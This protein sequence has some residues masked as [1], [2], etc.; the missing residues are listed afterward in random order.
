MS[1]AFKLRPTGLLALA[2]T[3]AAMV[4][5]MIVV[6]P[7]GAAAP[8]KEFT[9]TFEMPCSIAGGLVHATLKVETKAK[10]PEFV[11]EGETFEFTEASSTVTAPA[12]LSTELVNGFGATRAKG[13]VK[14]TMVKAINSTPASENIAVTKLFPEGLPYEAPVEKEKPQVFTAPHLTTYNFPEPVSGAAGYTVTGTAGQNVELKLEHVNGGIESTLE[15]FNASGARVVSTT[16][17]CEP[18]EVT[19]GQPI[20]IRPAVTETTEYKNIVVSGSLTVKRL[21]EAITLPE[22]STFNGQGEVNTGTGAG[23]V[24]GSLEI[25][26]FDA[27]LRVFGMIPLTLH[28][29]IKQMGPLEGSVAKSATVPGDED[30]TIPLSLSFDTNQVRVFGMKIPGKC[31]TLAPVSLAL[32]DTLTREELLTGSWSFAG[33]TTLPQ[34][35]CTGVMGTQLGFLLSVL[36]SGPG[37]PYSLKF[38]P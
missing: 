3:L 28:V 2:S 12:S 29:H 32:M 22:G 6:A 8:T 23:S 30:L 19:L 14:K 37:N 10:G 27:S 34:F 25:P 13:F 31:T 35:S 20:P 24:K 5:S 16:S 15:A 36:L 26:P 9:A 18:P 21:G 38:S 17:V 7:G 33:T 11:T 4:V 1:R